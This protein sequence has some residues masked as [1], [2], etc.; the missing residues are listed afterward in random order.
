MGEGR[1]MTWLDKNWAGVGNCEDYEN[2]K[3]RLRLVH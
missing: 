2:F 1:L 3:L